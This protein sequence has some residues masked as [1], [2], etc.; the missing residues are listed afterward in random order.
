MIAGSVS[1]VYSQY[2]NKSEI[3]KLS[4]INSFD[5]QF[6][7][8]Y[9]SKPLNLQPVTFENLLGQ[10]ASGFFIG[11]AGTVLIGLIGLS[12]SGIRYDPG[13][14]SGGSN[15]S[16][17]A[18]LLFLTLMASAQIFGSSGGVYAVGTNKDVG[19]DYGTTLLGSI[20][21]F[22]VEI[23]GIFL[24]ISMLNNDHGKKSNG[25]GYLVGFASI[26]MPTV[27]AM[28]GLNAKRYP[29]KVYS[30]PKSSLN[31]SKEKFYVST[32]SIYFENDKSPE[33]NLITFTKILN[34]SF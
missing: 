18:G 26:S 4:D 9:K 17:F 13:G 27:G 33:R 21:G 10:Y 22:A 8:L 31:I 3:A 29:K 30:S 7:S 19:S 11:N 5:S 24:T 23:G 34:I 16:P 25:F 28:I 32:P 12:A 6:D 1:P 2:L 20:C 15:N 14:G